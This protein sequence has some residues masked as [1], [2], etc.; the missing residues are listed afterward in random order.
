MKLNRKLVLVLSLV[1]SLALATGSTLAYLT[2]R[3]SDV[4]VFTVG[5]V[6]IDL[7]ETFD[8][9]STLLPGVDIEKKPIITNTGRNDAWVWATI[10]IPAALDTPA[11]ASQNIIHFNY[12]KASVEAGL[13]NWSDANGNWM[14][15]EVQIEGVAYNL[16]TVLYETALKPGESTTE[17]VI[18]KVYLDPHV[19]V[20]P[21]GQMYWVEKGETT[22]LDWNVKEIGPAMYVSAYAIQTAGFDSVQA[23]YAAYAEQWGDNAYEFS[24]MSQ[25]A[26]NADEL[27][28]ALANGGKIYLSNDVTGDTTVP[29]GANVEIDLQGN[30]LSG[31]IFTN[32]GGSVAISNGTIEGADYVQ[33]NS[34]ATYTNLTVESGSA[35]NYSVIS[36]AD[37]TFNN[38]DLDT[39]GGGIGVVNGSKVVFNSGSIDL[40]STSTSGRYLFFLE[41][42]GSEL[43]INGG[44]FDFNKTQNQKRAYIY[45]GDGTTVYVTGGTFGAASTRSGFTDG[46]LTA[47]TGTV[48]ITG[49]TF[50]FNPSKW[51]ADGYEAVQSGT[52][53]TV[54]KK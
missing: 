6:S 22:K 13:W 4:N 15:D 46:I 1:L 51:V 49:G 32:E 3:D 47:G 48:V 25:I 8:Q 23:A 36:L 28:A 53:W 24:A 42:A 18:T 35:S 34:P 31:T 37:A 45:A 21:D 39:A 50:G 30:T 11:D 41:G 26:G 7:T 54:A 40:N 17:P 12:T 29:A 14:I 43:T 33:N 10:A 20:A 52:T 2:D 27:A 19:D 5:D 16:Y 44:S 38:V 9:G